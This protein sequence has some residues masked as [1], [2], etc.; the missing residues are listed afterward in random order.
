MVRGLPPALN[1]DVERSL[2][3]LLVALAGEGLIESAHDCSDG[4]LAV[5]LAECCFDTGAIGADVSISRTGISKNET[6]NTAAALF[7]ESSSR[8]IVSARPEHVA[9][10][11]DRAAG[12]N[13]PARV[14]GRVGG[15]AL[16][17]AIDGQLAIDVAIDEAERAWT[18]AIEHYFARRVA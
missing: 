11:L 10:I 9:A 14:I 7:G 2:Q 13:V 3:T 1:L 17:I 4:G 8:V 15:A 5:T 16:R 18:S 12:G 6:L